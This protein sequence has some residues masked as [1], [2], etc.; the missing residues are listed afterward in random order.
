MSFFPVFTSLNF[1]GSPGVTRRTVRAN[2]LPQPVATNDPTLIGN[3][4]TE[5]TRRTEL[6]YVVKA[7]TTAFGMN[8]N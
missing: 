4:A 3:H 8:H 2:D 7:L 5:S 6:M 1:R